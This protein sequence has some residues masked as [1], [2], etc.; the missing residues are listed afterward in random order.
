MSISFENG[1]QIKS[2]KLLY[3]VLMPDLL[4]WWEINLNRIF[5]WE[6]VAKFNIMDKSY[7]TF[8]SINN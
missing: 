6:T 5:L 8:R 2:A 4:K 7:K 3:D 1:R